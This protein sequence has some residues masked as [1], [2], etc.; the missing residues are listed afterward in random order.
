MWLFDQLSDTHHRVWV[1]NLYMTA[2]FAK[3]SFN[4]KNKILLSGV[5]RGEKGGIPVLVIQEAEKRKD[6]FSVRGT[7]KAAVLEGDDNCPGLLVAIS[8]YDNRPVHFLS[9]AAESLKWIEKE[10]NV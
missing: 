6:E 2:R 4:S 1:D 9:M 10:R 3:Q 7:T 5:V 8:V